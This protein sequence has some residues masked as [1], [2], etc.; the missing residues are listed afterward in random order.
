MCR[1]GAWASR[2]TSPAPCTAAGRLA[3]RGRCSWRR[4]DERG[5]GG[6]GVLSLPSGWQR[7]G[8]LDGRGLAGTTEVEPA[9]A[10]ATLGRVTGTTGTSPRSNAR[11]VLTSIEFGPPQFEILMHPACKA[12]SMKDDTPPGTSRALAFAA[13]MKHSDKKAW[14]QG[15][16]PGKRS[17]GMW[18][19]ERVASVDRLT[20]ISLTLR[21]TKEL[22]QRQRADVAAGSG[23][24]KCQNRP[25]SGAKGQ[26]KIALSSKP[27]L[28]THFTLRSLIA[29]NH[30]TP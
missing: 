5:A 1:C 10:D 17:S 15:S 28:V 2:R 25:V 12:A 8:A 19:A 24:G 7:E 29:Q 22:Q 23:G 13:A 30:L 21:T 3:L 27:T 16:A 14:T 9:W 4:R 18:P 20:R 6:G 26:G 11:K